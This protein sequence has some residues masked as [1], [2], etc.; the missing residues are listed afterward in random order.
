MTTAGSSIRR[1][2]GP[3]QLKSGRF[4]VTCLTLGITGPGGCRRP[5]PSLR[6]LPA[7]LDEASAGSVDLFQH[8][9]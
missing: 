1:P 9:N 4:Y 5:M 3:V 6:P 7:H 8:C 2:G